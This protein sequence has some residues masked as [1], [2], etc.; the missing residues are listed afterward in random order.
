MATPSVPVGTR[1]TPRPSGSTRAGTSTASAT[2]PEGTQDL[3]PVSTQPSPSRSATVEGARGLPPSS[4]RAVVSTRVPGDHTGQPPLP[5]VRGPEPG[6]GRCG[7]GEGLHDRHVGGGAA[8]GLGEEPGLHEAEPRAADVL[9]EGDAEQPGRGQLGPELAV[10][11]V[12][13]GLGLEFAEAL[14]GRQVG[15]DAVGQVADGLLL[16]AE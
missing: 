7:G 1:N 3:V 2:V 8:G 13:V 15:E 6:D 10:E 11:P 9:G 14:V 5:L 12:T 16:L 4:T